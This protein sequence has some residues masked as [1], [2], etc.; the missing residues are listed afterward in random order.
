MRLD[1]RL[2]ARRQRHGAQVVALPE[3]H[4]VDAAEIAHPDPAPAREGVVGRGGED[5]RVVEERRGH[6]QRVG[7]RQ[8]DQGQ[9][10]LARRHL[11]H[12]LVRA[13][14]HHRQVD[15]RV[16]G[17]EGHQR[18]GQ[19]AGDEAG[20]GPDGQAP[21]GHARQRPRLGPGGRHVGQHPLHE[22][23]QRGPVGR[24]RD[25][26]LAGTAVEEEHAQ[27]VLEQADLARQ[28]GLGQVQPGGGLREALLLGHGQGVR[29]LMELHHSE[30][31]AL[32][33]MLFMSLTS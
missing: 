9:V 18:G 26:A 14:L 30:L 16:A 23:H 22:G 5:Q 31:I 28:R 10:D 13:G 15:A 21:P 3:H 7:H 4:Q 29:Q 25:G 12:Q 27:L 11:G 19:R 32:I 8:H 1:P 2:P 24:E 6:H 20:G 17:V 33:F